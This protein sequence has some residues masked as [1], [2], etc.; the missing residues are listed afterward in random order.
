MYFD[1]NILRINIQF[2]KIERYI[3]SELSALLS[4]RL[5][6][7]KVKNLNLNDKNSDWRLKESVNWI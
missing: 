2:H 5:K 3:C 4:Y 1:N 6:I 7:S